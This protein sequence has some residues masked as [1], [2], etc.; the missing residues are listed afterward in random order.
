LK[1]EFELVLGPEMRRK[2]KQILLRDPLGFR[3]WIVAKK[4][5]ALL[6]EKCFIAG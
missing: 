6:K 4:R 5:K 2:Q 3:T 1:N